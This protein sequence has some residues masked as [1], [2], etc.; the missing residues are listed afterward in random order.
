MYP[1]PAKKYVLALF[2]PGRQHE[3][4]IK[5]CSQTSLPEGGFSHCFQADCLLCMSG[6]EQT[7]WLIIGPAGR[8]TKKACRAFAGQALWHI[9]SGITPR[10][11]P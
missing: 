11:A 3:N 1:E 9:Q 5:L 10:Q 8:I 4:T 2:L 7:P 6:T